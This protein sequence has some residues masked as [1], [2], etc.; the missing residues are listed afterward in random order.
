M[1]DVAAS[2]FRHP[3]R[4]VRL[5]PILRL[6][7]LAA[8][9]QL[10]AIFIVVQGL[11]FDVPIVPCVTIIGLSALL[12][13]VLQITFNPMQRLEP[14]YAAALLA[15]NIVELAA[16]LFF[17]GGLQ[18]PFSFLF[19]APVLISATALPIRLT[20]APRVLAVACASALVF[21]P[22]P[23]QLDSAEPLVLPPVCPFS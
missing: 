13:L 15:L 19:P 1:T 3:R 18:N 23:L 4:Y 20:I 17:T 16:L 10:A 7:W 14:V 12:N 2:D 22:L 5:D 21:F 8:L 9:G 6:R 11:E